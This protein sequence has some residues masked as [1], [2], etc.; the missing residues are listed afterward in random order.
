MISFIL[1]ISLKEGYLYSAYCKLALDNKFSLDRT[2]NREEISQQDTG[3]SNSPLLQSPQTK[4]N[5][6]NSKYYTTSFISFFVYMLYNDSLIIV[7][8]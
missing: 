4:K 2:C 3:S 7:I 8:G 6:N 1:I 5:Y